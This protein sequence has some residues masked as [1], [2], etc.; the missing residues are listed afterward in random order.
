MDF[1]FLRTAWVQKI[2]EPSNMV[3]DMSSTYQRCT[4]VK[5]A[6]IWKLDRMLCP[7]AYPVTADL[8]RKFSHH[9]RVRDNA[10][11]LSKFNWDLP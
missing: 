2:S 7:Q 3:E 11:I 1:N 8:E 4:V 9:I 10:Y 6:R 5:P